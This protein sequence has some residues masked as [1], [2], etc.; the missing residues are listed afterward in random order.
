MCSA[1]LDLEYLLKDET[2]HSVVYQIPHLSRCFLINPR[3]S[4]DGKMRIKTEGINLRVGYK[5]HLIPIN[6]T[7]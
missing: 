4:T 2:E 7:V 5:Y 6:N 1:R 3:D